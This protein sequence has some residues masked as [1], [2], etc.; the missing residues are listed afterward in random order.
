MIAVLEKIHAVEADTWTNFTSLRQMFHKHYILW[1]IS[2]GRI[3]T[4][5]IAKT[6]ILLLQCTWLHDQQLLKYVTHN[7]RNSITIVQQC[8]HMQVHWKALCSKSKKKKKYLTYT[9]NHNN[10]FIHEP[11]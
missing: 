2:T 4:K 9:D 7:C 5:K 10:R 11:N 3:G 6:A 1:V 8:I